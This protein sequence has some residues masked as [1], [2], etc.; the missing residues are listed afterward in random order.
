VQ[1]L[2]RLVLILATISWV[3]S[4][5]ILFT[6]LVKHQE[7][8]DR[9]TLSSAISTAFALTLA[10]LAII[11]TNRVNSAE[12]NAE[13]NL[14]LHVLRLKS[15]LRLMKYRAAREITLRVTDSAAHPAGSKANHA[16]ERKVVE[17]F[18]VTPTA[19]AFWL[20]VAKQCAGVSEGTPE[21]WRIFFLNLLIL[22]DKSTREEAIYVSATDVERKLDSLSMSDIRWLLGRHADLSKALSDHAWSDADKADTILKA[23][24]DVFVRD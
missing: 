5:A 11:I 1:R 21:K 23:A 8:A 13:Q 22:T 17:E 9:G 4:T 24:D 6:P 20:F 3:V 10:I 12:H 16:T 7:F 2:T 15:A 18:L 19:Y 14:K